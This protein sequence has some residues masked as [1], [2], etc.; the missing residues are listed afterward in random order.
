MNESLELA[1]NI[2]NIQPADIPAEVMEIT[3]KS[4]L[5]GIGTMLAAGGLSEECRPFVEMSL[6]NGG[7]QESTIIG[8]KIKVPA[9]MAAF[10]NGSMSHVL[11][12]EDYGGGVHA[13]AGTIPAALAESEALGG[14]SGREFL[15]A[16]ALGSDLVFRLSLA[17]GIDSNPVKAGWYMPPI[18]G[19]MGAAAAVGKL[20]KLNTEQ[21]LDALCLTMCQATFSIE[22]G[23]P[24]STIRGVREAFVAK[25]AVI[26]PRL[27]Q[28]GVLGF[29]QPFESKGGFFTMYMQG[30]Y[31]PDVLLK[32]LGK[33]FRGAGVGFKPWPAC[34]F[35]HPYAEEALQI[36]R[37][38]DIKPETIEEISIV[39]DNTSETRLVWEPVEAKK[40]PTTSPG[41]KFSIPFVVATALVYKKVALDHFSEKALSDPAV[42]ALTSK[43]KYDIV[44]KAAASTRGLVSVKTQKG[45]IESKRVQYIYGEPQ[46]PMSGEALIEKFRDCVSHAARKL[47]SKQ[48][49][50]L[51]NLLLNLEKVRDMKEISRYL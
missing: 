50:E 26:G 5:D 9:A 31:N 49:E 44:D 8:Q 51:I 48:V 34:A 37:A 32:G 17:R 42:L 21:M 23:S 15:T 46:N 36:A 11:D 3:K 6:E 28:K 47:N 33:E 22:I 12:F 45:T 7:K 1:K 29:D 39:V 30:K 25:A 35:T 20:R 14:I 10:A 27:A 16:M 38:N 18:L 2:V 13:N 40:K 41:A 24:R 19:A 4:F 43:I